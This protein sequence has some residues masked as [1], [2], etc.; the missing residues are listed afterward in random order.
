MKAAHILHESAALG[1]GAELTAETAARTRAFRC[2]VEGGQVALMMCD[3]H[4]RKVSFMSEKLFMGEEESNFPENNQK[5]SW[6][7][8]G[9][10][11]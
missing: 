4:S 9:S 2:E 8:K 7:G 11:D 1:D 5:T 10:M 3:V 6:C